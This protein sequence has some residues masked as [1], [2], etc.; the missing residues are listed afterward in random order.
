MERQTL[1]YNCL[2][3]VGL[4]DFAWLILDS[5]FGSVQMC[6]NEINTRQC[7]MKSN[8]LFHQKIGSLSLELLMRL[9][10]SHNNDITWLNAWEFVSLS[11][12]SVLVVVGRTLVDLSFEN[13]LLFDDLFAIAGFALIFFIDDFARAA[14]LVARALRLTVHA[15]S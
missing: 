11:V 3:V 5:N 14:A 4:N 2:Q 6:Y 12:E 15:G 9:L 13:L 8:L 7:L 1:A 10:L